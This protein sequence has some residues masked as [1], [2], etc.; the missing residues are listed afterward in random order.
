[1][2]LTTHES[3]EPETPEERRP[4]TAPKEVRRTQ[5]IEATIDCIA[6]RGISGTTMAQVTRRAGLSVGIV[7]LHFESKDNLLTSTLVHLS[8]QV[9]ATWAEIAAAP[10]L[11]PA[12]KLRRIALASFDPAIFNPKTIAVW[13][14][15]FGE[16]EYRRFYRKMVESYDDERGDVLQ[17]LCADLTGGAAG[18]ARDPSVVTNA[19]ECF[20]DGLWLNAI[21]YPDEFTRDYCVAQLEGFLATQFPGCFAPPAPVAEGPA[22]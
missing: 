5:L 6:E 20:S 19:I 13:F 21:V 10:D 1:M 17:A 2:T 8:E 9:R 3:V 14:A 7:S 11:P 18:D 15:F 22:A 12:E 4:R 16:A